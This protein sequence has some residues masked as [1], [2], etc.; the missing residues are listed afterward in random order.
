MKM[1]SIGWNRFTR[2][3]RKAMVVGIFLYFCNFDASLEF[4]D[5]RLSIVFF[6]AT[7]VVSIFS[8]NITFNYRFA[9]RVSGYK[10]GLSTA[11]VSVRKMFMNFIFPHAL[12]AIFR[13]MEI[14]PNLW[15]SFTLPPDC[16]IIQLESL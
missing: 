6:T 7:A 2:Y 15:K 8:H 5:M 1:T 12:S 9:Q 16:I 4:V 13:F 3:T 14:A 11:Y 10:V